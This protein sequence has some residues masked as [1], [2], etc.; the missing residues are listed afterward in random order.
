MVIRL[1]A[2][3]VSAAAA[4][5]AVVPQ[6]KYPASTVQVRESRDQLPPSDITDG[7]PSP[8]VM[9][10][11]HSASALSRSTVG[12]SSSESLRSTMQNDNEFV[13]ATISIEGSKGGHHQ[14]PAATSALAVPA[15]TRQRFVKKVAGARDVEL[16]QASPS[17]SLSS[18]SS[19]KRSSRGND[20]SGGV[21]PGQSIVQ[22]S[23]AD[24]MKGDLP[25]AIVMAAIPGYSDGG[26]DD[27]DVQLTSASTN[28]SRSV[29]N[30]IAMFEQQPI[31]SES[32]VN[33]SS[34]DVTAASPD[35]HQKMPPSSEV[36]RPAAKGPKRRAP[37]PMV[38]PKFKLNT[39]AG[40]V[41][42]TSA[43]STAS[44]A[45]GGQGGKSAQEEQV[46]AVNDGDEILDST[47][48]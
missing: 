39:S 16:K 18:G 7:N 29:A 45:P 38:N 21:S 30:R 48:L 35:S 31:S 42:P 8:V 6:Q 17:S 23:G 1:D 10:T 32:S 44:P 20:Q 46:S 47:R 28:V 33:V 4:S 2:K 24:Q 11:I 41:T 36:S 34:I 3:P 27:T 9:K 40:D 19:G 13:R 22:P 12:E 15:L 5:A 26:S 43:K 25:S 37:V 14:Q